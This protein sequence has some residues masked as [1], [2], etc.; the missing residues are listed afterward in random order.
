M[1]TNIGDL[2]LSSLQTSNNAI[3]EFITFWEQKTKEL[4]PTFIK[5]IILDSIE[6]IKSNLTNIRLL[7]SDA[8]TDRHWSKIFSIF[9]IS[10]KSYRD[11]HLKHILDIVDKLDGNMAEVKLIVSKAHAEQVIKTAIVEVE[12]WSTTINLTLIEHIDSKGNRT[13]LVKGIPE[14]LNKARH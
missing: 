1:Q 8:L 6:N 9:G 5:D 3:I 10:L 12:Q 11:I 2:E 14:I 7:Q 13:S 4:E